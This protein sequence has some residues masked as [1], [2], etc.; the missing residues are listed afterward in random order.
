MAYAGITPDSVFRESV[1]SMTMVIATFSAVTSST[2]TSGLP[3]ALTYW[4]AG[5]ST[6]ISVSTAMASA[7]ASGS[8]AGV[9]FYLNSGG[10]G[11]AQS[12]R[13]VVLS[14]V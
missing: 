2:W 1:G 5:E 14:R 10:N 8:S 7:S 11:G 3:N 13:L 9:Y 4:A 6:G 12:G